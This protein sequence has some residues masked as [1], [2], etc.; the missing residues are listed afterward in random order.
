MPMAIKQELTDAMEEGREG[1]VRFL[2]EH[3]VLPVVVERQ[4]SNLLGG[5]QTPDFAFEAQSDDGTEP[6]TDRQTRTTIVDE[7]GLDSEEDCETL[8]EEI[9]AH[10]SWSG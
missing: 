3:Q 4:S 10:D 7:L 6:L 8:R 2:A 9:K 1:I 5:S